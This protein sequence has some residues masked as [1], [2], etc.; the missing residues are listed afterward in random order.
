MKKAAFWTLYGLLLFV[1]TIAG[2]EGLASFQTPAWPAYELRPI[3]ATGPSPDTNSWGL[4]DRER[5]VDRPPSVHHRVAFV[6]D[7]FLEGVLT[8]PLS[9][10]VERLWALRGMVGTEAVNLG[11]AAT[12]PKQYYYRIKT[13]ALKLQP[14]A[15]LLMFYSG[16]DFVSNGVS[17][18]TPPPFVAERPEPSLLGS[19]AP[20]LTW[21]ASNRLGLSEFGRGNK[22]IEN[23]QGLLNDILHQPRGERTALLAAHLKKFYYPDESE[24][25]LQEIL[26][27]GGERFWQPFENGK[28][29]LAGW[30]PASIIRHETSSSPVP[31]DAA[32]ADRM[33]DQAK[34]RATTTWL[35]SARSLAESRGVKFLLAIAPVGSVDPDYVEFW[36]P[37]PRYYSNNLQSEAN[38]RQLLVSLRASGFSP[39]DLETDLNGISGSYRLIDGHWTDHGTKVVAARIAAELT[40]IAP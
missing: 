3:D 8:P 1:V 25:R 21:L 26:A 29:I 33:V 2:L 4:K 20:K 5:S 24:A 35:S 38:R 23:E 9:R 28:A 16:N 37:W 39:I 17:R 7:S 6:G 13:V 22:N 32:E 14:D 10:E 27:R 12:G 15:I 18:L 30:I 34:I 31:R 40:D 11:V 36:K 19:L